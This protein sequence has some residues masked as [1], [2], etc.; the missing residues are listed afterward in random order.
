MIPR[1]QEWAWIM[2]AVTE[3][4]TLD[5]PFSRWQPDALR[6]RTSAGH[7]KVEVRRGGAFSSAW[8][9]PSGDVAVQTSRHLPTAWR[10]S[11]FRVP[12]LMPGGGYFRAANLRILF[13]RRQILALPPWSRLSRRLDE[14]PIGLHMHHHIDGLQLRVTDADAAADQLVSVG[15]VPVANA[16]VWLAAR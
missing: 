8:T 3:W 15:V 9:L 13:R 2:V 11:A 1:W 16:E 4:T 12:N 10:P 5:I 7:I 14:R 6:I